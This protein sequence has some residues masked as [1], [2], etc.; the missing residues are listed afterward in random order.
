MHKSIHCIKIEPEIWRK[1]CLKKPDKSIFFI[2]WIWSVLVSLIWVIKLFCRSRCHCDYDGSEWEC[3]SVL[4]ARPRPLIGSPTRV[5]SLQPALALNLSVQTLSTLSLT[6]TPRQQPLSAPLITPPDGVTGLLPHW[7]CSLIHILIL[8]F[9]LSYLDSLC[10][11]REWNGGGFKMES[12][13]YNS[14]WR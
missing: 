5:L 2:V 6:L 7:A 3:Q 4:A 9:F 14:A 10:V 8:I 1:E 11:G 13:R 12:N